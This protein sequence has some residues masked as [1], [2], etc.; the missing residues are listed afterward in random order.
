MYALEFVQIAEVILFG[1]NH[2]R[3]RKLLTKLPGELH[4]FQ[5]VLNH[6][7]KDLGSSGVRFSLFQCFE[8]L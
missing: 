6:E 1:I 5:T 3:P 7:H 2:P 4:R 8:G